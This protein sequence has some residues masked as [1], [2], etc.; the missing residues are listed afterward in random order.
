MQM[1]PN[2]PHPVMDDDG[3]DAA[4]VNA[5]NSNE[6]SRAERRRLAAIERKRAKKAA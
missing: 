1:P 2:M 4:S 5:R 3:V 6:L